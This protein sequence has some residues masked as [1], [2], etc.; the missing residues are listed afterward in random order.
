[1]KSLELMYAFLLLIGQQ[2]LSAS[3]LSSVAIRR[4]AAT[5][6]AQ[7]EFVAI[8]SDIFVFRLSKFSFST[9]TLEDQLSTS[10]R[11]SDDKQS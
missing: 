4:V 2:R 6:N 1:M 10:G 9:W 5:S 11:Q 3:A 8:R 7:Q